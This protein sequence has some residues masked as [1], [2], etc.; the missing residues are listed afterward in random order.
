MKLTF[1]SPYLSITSLPEATLPEFTVLT[2][3]NGSGKTH[4]MQA[5]VNGHISASVVK[6]PKADVRYFD[7]VSITP[8]NTDNYD[9]HS[10]AQGIVSAY[11]LFNNLRNQHKTQLV[12]II[13][14]SP[15]AKLA[16]S[17]LKDVAEMPTERLAEILDDPAAATSLR[18]QMD[19]SIDAI[20][21]NVR[22]Q[23]GRQAASS[24][25]A[26]ARLHQNKPRNLF[27]IDQQ[28]FSDA[29]DPVWGQAEPFR[30][31]FAQLFGAYR[32]L[33][34]ENRLQG[35]CYQDGE[36][37]VPPLSD[38]EFRN[39]YNE[40]PWDFVNRSLIEGGLDF[41]IDSPPLNRFGPYKPVL[42]KRSSGQEVEFG[43]LSSGEK[44][45]MSFALCV[46]YAQDRRQLSP[47]PPLLLL[48]EVDAPLHPSMC[49][50][51]VRT[52]TEVL[53]PTCGLN[54]I[55]ATHAPTTVA[56]SPEE[57][58]HVMRNDGSGITKTS[59]SAA[60]SILTC[61]VPTVSLDFEGRRQ[62][63]VE[64][65]HDARLY[66]G[67]Y[68]LIKGRLDA[69]RSLEFIGVGRTPHEGSGCDQVRHI[70]GSLVASG[71]KTVFGIVDW[72]NKNIG[73]DRIC[74]M[75]PGSRH[76]LEN[77]LLDPLLIAILLMRDAPTFLPS[78]GFQEITSYFWFKDK[79]RSALQPIV[80][81]IVCSAFPPTG[82]ALPL[83]VDY[84]GGL[85]LMVDRSYLTVRGHDLE[86]RLLDV[87]PPLN[88]NAGDAAKLMG[89]IVE[90]VC[91]DFPEYV[92]IEFRDCFTKI[93]SVVS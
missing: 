65:T 10:R 87:F 57:S 79:G 83:R 64:S 37:S 93:L 84:M 39:K 60:L 8:N 72:D 24:Q 1:Q 22:G 49:R 53:I 33:V 3:L 2:G 91:C 54:V 4:L 21:K 52:I 32:D 19:A 31:A 62:V 7:W 36:S 61:G 26:I 12:Q 77:C 15:L 86:R 92:P 14:R 55:L 66:D 40:A 51:L 13:S 27:A 47:Y 30:Q 28:V 76:S 48:D 45:L 50:Q 6:N 78:K 17:D 35:L 46:Y 23:L 11:T 68:R 73:N 42:R 90:S 16:A 85:S 29:I 43:S 34:V 70:V 5:I 69:E 18:A 59:K 74:V 75:A 56:I 20:W 58:I 41:F 81:T 63:I 9:S 80:D 38:Q 71:N 89:H 25:N 44:V 67:I 82:A 88:R